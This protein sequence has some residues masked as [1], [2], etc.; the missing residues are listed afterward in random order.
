MDFK[1]MAENVARVALDKTFAGKNIGEIAEGAAE[2]ALEAAVQEIP[3][4][5]PK[6]NPT[7]TDQV[8]GSIIGSIVAVLGYFLRKL[9][10]K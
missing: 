9:L 4:E 1:K 5:N 8:R 10:L 2:T 6:E 3:T 7:E